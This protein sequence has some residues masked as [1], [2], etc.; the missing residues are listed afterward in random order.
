MSIPP[1][2]TLPFHDWNLKHKFGKEDYRTDYN[3]FTLQRLVRG[4][5]YHRQL[6]RYRPWHRVKTPSDAFEN[7]RSIPKVQGLK[8]YDCYD[9]E[10]ESQMKAA[11]AERFQNNKAAAKSINDPMCIGYLSTMNCNSVQHLIKCCRL[12]RLLPNAFFSMTTALTI[13]IQ[14]LNESWG[15]RLLHGMSLKV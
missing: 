4:N 10:S 14:K 11:R 7:H 1:D 13:T 3:N 2:G 12:H 8:F 5:E 15:T 9:G 6:E